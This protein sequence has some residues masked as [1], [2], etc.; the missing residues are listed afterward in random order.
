MLVFT[1]VSLLVSF[2]RAEQEGCCPCLDSSSSSSSSSEWTSSS[3][4]AHEPICCNAVLMNYDFNQFVPTVGQ[5][6]EYI[7]APG[8]VSNDGQYISKGCAGYQVDS[9][10]F[11]SWQLPSPTPWLDHNKWFIQ[12]TEP[13]VIKTGDVL[14]V[15]WKTSVKTFRT[16]ESPYP[17]L[18]V[19]D[20]DL[21]LAAGLYLASDATT[22]LNF[23]FIL[24][25]DRVY[26]LYMKYIGGVDACS[27]AWSF[28]IPLKARKACDINKIRLEFNEGCK[29][30]GYQVDNQE[31]YRI[32]KVGEKLSNSALLVK[33]YA[34]QVDEDCDVPVKGCPCS[35]SDDLTYPFA[36]TFGFGTATFL[37]WYPACKD[38]SCRH[39]HFPTLRTGLLN[40]GDE[41][42][43]QA[44]SIFEGCPVPQTYYQ[45]DGTQ[46][47]YHIWGQG[48]EM[49]LGSFKVERYAC[50]YE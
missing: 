15:E 7:T 19:Q 24:T 21:R 11:N 35:S 32:K 45:N 4:S 25:N 23:G 36:L 49:D 14:G 31:L 47:V 50:Y 9:N 44:C 12:T 38:R 13:L 3:S 30:V 6:W 2:I 27:G 37:D 28:V 22:A 33:E 46:E 1:L 43:P 26:G 5:G 10:P 39:C 42:A 48:V 18:V 29:Y 20:N 41:D 40:L 34:E 16:G 17:E 8:Y